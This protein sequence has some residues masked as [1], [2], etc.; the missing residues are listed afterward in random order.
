MS[1]T[2]SLM[3]S[4]LIMIT[5]VIL[6]VMLMVTLGQIGDRFISVLID[7]VGATAVNADWSGGFS[8]MY[9]MQ[10]FLF[11]L[12]CFPG[13]YGVVVFIIAAVRRQTYDTFQEPH[14]DYSQQY[15]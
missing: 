4:F 6:S 3:D 13:I 11:V 2:D 9:T 5:F 14:I 8:S 12:C 10:T 15:K 7:D 1:S